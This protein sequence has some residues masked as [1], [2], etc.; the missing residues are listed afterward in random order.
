MVVAVPLCRKAY[1]PTLCFSPAYLVLLAFPQCIACTV[2]GQGGAGL[3]RTGGWHP[4]M[5]A[6]VHAALQSAFWVLGQPC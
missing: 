3:G 2:A 5:H 6:H 4:C 1:L